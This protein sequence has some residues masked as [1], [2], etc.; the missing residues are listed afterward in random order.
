[1]GKVMQSDDN[2]LGATRGRWWWIAIGIITLA[3][4]GVVVVFAMVSSNQLERSWAIAV[5]PL[6]LIAAAATRVLTVLKAAAED[7]GS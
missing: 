5:L 4:S 7:K 6:A 3:L 1:M 2:S